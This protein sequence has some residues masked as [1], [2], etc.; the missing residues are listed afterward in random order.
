MGGS[1]RGPDSPPEDRFDTRETHIVV[2]AD[3]DR[4]TAEFGMI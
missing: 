2:A 3:I 4:S 1:V